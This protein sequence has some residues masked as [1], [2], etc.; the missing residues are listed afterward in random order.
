M[1]VQFLVHLHML[2]ELIRG[3]LCEAKNLVNIFF[4]MLKSKA[5]DEEISFIK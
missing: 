5:S 4:E 2:V 3:K 1:D